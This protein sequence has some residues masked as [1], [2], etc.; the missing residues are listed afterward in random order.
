VYYNLT[1]LTIS[2]M[3]GVLEEHHLMFQKKLKLL[4]VGIWIAKRIEFKVSKIFYWHMK[5]Q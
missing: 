1:Q 2:F 3:F 5:M 4:I